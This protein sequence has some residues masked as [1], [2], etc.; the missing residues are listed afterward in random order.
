MRGLRRWND[1][2]VRV[3]TGSVFLPK[4]NPNQKVPVGC[5]PDEFAASV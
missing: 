4:L 2:M 5:E 3:H 1:V